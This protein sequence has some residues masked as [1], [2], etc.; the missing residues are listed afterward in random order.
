MSYKR[1]SPITPYHTMQSSA[2]PQQTDRQW[3]TDVALKLITALRLLEMVTDDNKDIVDD[4]SG[5]DTDTDTDSDNA[6]V[7]SA[8]LSTCLIGALADLQSERYLNKRQEIEK[9]T[10]IISLL[11]GSWKSTHPEIFRDYLRIT[12]PAFNKLLEDIK[13]D[14]VFSNNSDTAEQLQVQHQLA[15]DPLPLLALW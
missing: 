3:T 12:L 4:E 6:I 2:M 9:T 1:T 15:I 11:L 10:E 14:P 8:S 7:H 5:S 13:D